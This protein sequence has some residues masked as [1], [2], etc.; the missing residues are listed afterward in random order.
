M[1]YNS[2]YQTKQDMSQDAQQFENL[3]E[4][5]DWN[6]SSIKMCQSNQFENE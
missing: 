2:N 4:E 5:M 1:N 3:L 6:D